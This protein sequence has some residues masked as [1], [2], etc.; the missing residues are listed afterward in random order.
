MQYYKDDL[1]LT[2]A[3]S[4]AKIYAANKSASFN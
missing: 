3:D 2:N 1:T 4:I